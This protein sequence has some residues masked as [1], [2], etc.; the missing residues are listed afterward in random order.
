VAIEFR[1]AQNKYDQLPALAADLVRRRVDVI[2]ATGR[3]CGPCGKG[4]ECDDS[5]RLPV[6]ADPIAARLV[7]SLS[8]PGGTKRA[9]LS[10]SSSRVST[11]RADDTHRWGIY[12]PSSSSANLQM[13]PSNPVH[14]SMLSCSRLYQRRPRSRRRLLH[15]HWYGRCA[16]GRVVQGAIRLHRSIYRHSTHFFGKLPALSCEEAH[17]SISK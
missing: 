9:L 13:R 14:T 5:N 11:I 12:H 7:V 1:W 4:S 8:R 17:A 15:L 3:T 2:A 10:S 6:A 16:P